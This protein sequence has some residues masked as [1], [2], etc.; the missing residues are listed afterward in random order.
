M[1]DVCTYRQRISKYLPSISIFDLFD[2]MITQRLSEPRS[3][4]Q[5]EEDGK[6]KRNTTT[7]CEQNSK[8]HNNKQNNR[9]LL[10][11]RKKE[12]HTHSNLHHKQ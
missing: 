7:S 3:Q 6:Q 8:R 2:F 10:L 12:G 5:V 1:A 4:Y 9:L 11:L